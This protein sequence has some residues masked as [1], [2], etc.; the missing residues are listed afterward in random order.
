M[1]SSTQNKISDY[2]AL[3][4]LKFVLGVDGFQ[5]ISYYIKK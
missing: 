1:R 2:N 4:D 3:E 5:C